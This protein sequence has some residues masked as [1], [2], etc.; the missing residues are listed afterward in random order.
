MH[1]VVA[2]LRDNLQLQSSEGLLKKKQSKSKIDS[3]AA[4]SEKKHQQKSQALH[5][6]KRRSS[7]TKEMYFWT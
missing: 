7:L 4:L 2:R 1:I 3:A 5:R 6:N